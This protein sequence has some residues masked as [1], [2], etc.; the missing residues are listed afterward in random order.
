MDG[1]QIPEKI[2]VFFIDGVGLGEDS[3]ENPL[4]IARM[5]TLKSW[6]G[7]FS[8]TKEALG[9]MKGVASLG[10]IDARLE[11]EGL[12]QSATGQASLLTGQNISQVLGRHW[13]GLPTKTIQ[14]RLLQFSL[15]K[16]LKSQGLRGCFANYFTKEYF[17]NAKN[18]RFPHSATTWSALAA[19]LDFLQDEK[20][21][22]DEQAIF[23]DLTGEAMDMK[24]RIVSPLE[25]GKRLGSIASVHDFTL[26]EYFLTDAA[27]HK[28]VW[29]DKI[30]VLENFDLA[31][32]GLKDSFD[33]SRN[34]LV[35]VSDHGNIEDVRRKTHTMNEVP[36]IAVGVGSEALV[37]HCHDLT[38]LAP[39]LR[40]WGRK[41]DLLS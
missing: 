3:P 30:T 26:Y 39:Y 8:L 1:D 4:T 23:F 38:D 9:K 16:T 21:L 19:D 11:V 28:E 34:L 13:P 18:R 7:G 37:K 33:L 24:E 6:L 25:S 15:F 35:I 29:Q 17:E 31:L 2:L 41:K 36:L 14:N 5:P 32:A 22:Q 27:G 20:A 40:W 10:A 12:P